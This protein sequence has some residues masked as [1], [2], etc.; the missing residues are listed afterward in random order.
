MIPIQIPTEIWLRIF[1]FTDNNTF[2]SLTKFILDYDADFGDELMQL[3]CR[4]TV[5]YNI[6]IVMMIKLINNYD[7]FVQRKNY[8]QFR[9]NFIADEHRNNIQLIKFI[10]DDTKNTV[11]YREY[12]LKNC[13]KIFKNDKKRL[14]MF[15]NQTRSNRAEYDRIDLE[16]LDYMKFYENKINIDDIVKYTVPYQI[17]H[18][19]R[20]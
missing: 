8:M 14:K 4:D 11:L 5:K 16:G 13:E 10:Y 19:L 2:Q 1:K 6:K 17:G 12:I 9:F 20:K 18:S 15:I 7:Y 3:V